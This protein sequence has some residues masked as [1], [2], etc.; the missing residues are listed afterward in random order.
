MGGE[1]SSSSSSSYRGSGGDGDVGMGVERSEE[2]PH[3]GHTGGEHTKVFLNEWV[4]PR[5]RRKRMAATLASDLGYEFYGQIGDFTDVYRMVKSDHPRR[6][7]RAAHHLTQHLNT[8]TQVVWAEQQ[9]VKER[10]KRT[11]KLFN[12]ELW[13]H[14]WY[15]FD[16]RTQEDLPKLDLQVLGVWQAG[17]TG[18]GVKV[19]I[20]DDGLEWRHSDIINSYDPEISYDFNYDKDDP[21]P[22]YDDHSSNAHGTRCAGEVVMQPNNYKCGVGVAHGAKVGGVKIL[23]GPV[24][25]MTEGRG[26]S[27]ALGKVDIVS[28]SWG[29]KDDGTRVEGPGTLAQL[30]IQ[31]GVKKG[32]D[33]KGIIY[34]WAAGNGG[35][36]GDNC[37]CDGYTSS[38][39]TLSIGSASETGQF[40]WYGERCT[41]TLATAY[42]SG[43]YTDQKI[44]TTDLNDTCTVK[45]T[46]TSASAPLAAGIVALA[47]Q[48][49]GNLTWRDMQHAVV[50]TSEWG[51][52]SHNTGWSTNGGGLEVNSRFGFGLLSA[53]G[54]VEAVQNWTNVAEQ[55]VCRVM[56]TDVSKGQLNLSNGEWVKVEISSDGCVGSENEVNWLEHIQLIT[57]INYTRRGSLSITLTSPHGTVADLLTERLM[58]GS[59]RGFQKW[60]FMSVHTWAENPRG[61]WTVNISDSSQM[62]ANGAV[63]E[64][65]L[66]LYGTKHK[67]PHMTQERVYKINTAQVEKMKKRE[68]EEEKEEKGDNNDNNNDN[69]KLYLTADQLR[70]LPWKQLVQLLTNSSK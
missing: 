46:G 64:I 59:S 3:E 62:T 39:H 4:V 50:W 33:G 65:E 10:T 69:N 22:R 53:Q 57:T 2:A 35:S 9:F 68:E 63:G 37:N 6:H 5:L 12:D 32:R 66:I 55:N 67:P 34:V 17:V 15:L 1:R 21:S 29:P 42:S 40:P 14:Q 47:L 7:K 25:D 26:L 44:A 28:C 49:N 30:A 61:T 24:S 45:F 48:V 27:Y 60:P 54:L 70:T 51:P 8:H 58:D 56:P 31:E 23:D 13:D 19:Q 38:I 41:S 16:T 11:E 20:I 52:L 36:A 18:R 43:A